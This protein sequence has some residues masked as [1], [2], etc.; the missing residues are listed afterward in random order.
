MNKIGIGIR[1]YFQIMDEDHDPPLY[2]YA[3]K[4]WV[5]DNKIF[6]RVAHTIKK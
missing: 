3:D 4:L 2:L 5:K 6:L 1:N